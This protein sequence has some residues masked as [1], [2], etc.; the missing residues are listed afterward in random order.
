VQEIV[1][2]LMED[3]RQAGDAQEQHEQCADQAGPFVDGAPSPQG[4]GR[5]SQLRYPNSRVSIVAVTNTMK[6]TRSRTAI[7]TRP[8][9]VLSLIVLRSR[10]ERLL[11]LRRRVPAFSAMVRIVL[12]EIAETGSASAGRRGVDGM[13]RAPFG[14][15]TAHI[16]LLGPIGVANSRDQCLPAAHDHVQAAAERQQ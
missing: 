8:V 12:S 5:R 13:L 10:N 4:F 16:V 1:D 6:D 11:E 15:R 9:W 3:Q 7:R 2:L 14:T